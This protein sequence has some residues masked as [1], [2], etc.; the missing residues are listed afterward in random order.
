MRLIL[1]AIACLVL[2]TQTAHADEKKPI[3]ATYGLYAGGVRMIGLTAL[4]ELGPDSYHLAAD[5][6][7][8]GI[9]AKLL[10]WWGKFD[11]V[12][13]SG[14][15]PAEHDYSVSWQDKVERAVFRYDPP[16]SFKGMT[17]TK[18]GKTEEPAVDPDIT[19]GTRDLLS[20]LML[21][22]DGY[23]R[24][25]SCARDV[26]AFDNARS[27]IV[28][29][30][31]AGDTVMNNP[32]LSSY[33]GPAHGCSV[34]IVPQKGKWPK[35]PRGWLII[36]QQAKAGGRLPVVWLATPAPGLP[37]IP[38]RVDIHTKYGDVIA[39]LSGLQ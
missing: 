33:T 27:F 24:T 12:G 1:V 3:N 9:F 30:R 17:L 39:H 15:E 13:G 37:V 22:V 26:L 4:Y 11:T 36:Q 29:F 28:R 10:P 21:A 14:F 19:A 25:Q 8:V 18:K 2:Y 35:K 6:R 34:E 16:G 38:V 23:A 32:R 7:T 31:D 20:T 5:A